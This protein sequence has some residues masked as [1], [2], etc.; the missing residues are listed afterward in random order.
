MKIKE[1]LETWKLSSLKFKSPFLEMEFKA[2]PVDEEAAWAL[3]VELVTR[4]ATQ[5]LMPGHG[6]EKTALESIHLLFSITRDVLKK[7]RGCD[8]FAPIAVAMLNQKIR[9]FTAKWH[10]I[11]LNKGFDDS[12]TRLE[13]RRELEELQ[14]VLRSYSSAL[15]KIANVEDLTDL[16]S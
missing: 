8:R 5:Q 4:I 13:F 12:E 11:A 1:L 3:H 9:P 6:D 10:P 16:E 2:S 7:N 15:S 14:N